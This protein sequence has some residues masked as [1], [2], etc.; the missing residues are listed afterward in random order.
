MPQH[1]GNGVSPGS[2]GAAL[3]IMAKNAASRKQTGCSRVPIPCEGLTGWFGACSSGLKQCTYFLVPRRWA[4]IKGPKWLPMGAL[5]SLSLFSNPSRTCR[6]VWY[7]DGWEGMRMIK[8][9]HDFENRYVLQR[10]VCLLVIV[11]AAWARLSGW[12]SERERWGKNTK[13]QKADKRE[14]KMKKTREDQKSP[15]SS[16]LSCLN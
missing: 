2:S 3:V 8:I 9:T 13:E 5:A 12:E 1:S 7:H 10:T 4:G 6:K 14:N 16:H 11:L 15:I